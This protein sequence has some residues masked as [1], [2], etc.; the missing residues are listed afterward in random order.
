MMT[1]SAELLC[2]A[3]FMSGLDRMARLIE[4]GADVN[5]AGPTGLTPLIQAAKRGSVA[6]VEMLITAGA[7]LDTCDH[8]GY[9]ALYWACRYR[10]SLGWCTR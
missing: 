9:Q 4:N 1:Q 7:R 3:G 8:D 2:I 10:Q 5:T 6:A